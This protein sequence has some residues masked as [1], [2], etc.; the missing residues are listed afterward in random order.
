MLCDSCM[1]Q[2][3]KVLRHEEVRILKFLNDYHYDE[4]LR[5]ADR[6]EIIEK[7]E[8]TLAIVATSL[9]RLEAS[10]LVGRRRIGRRNRYY[11]TKSGKKLLKTLNV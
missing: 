5:S 2:I 6:L 11:I 10:L 7:C 3:I 8:L 1:K 9:H 4:Q